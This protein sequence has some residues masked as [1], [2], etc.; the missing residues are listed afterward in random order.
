MRRLSSINDLRRYLAD[1]IRR[2]DPGTERLD[3]ATA[4]RLGNLLNLQK[5]FIT[6]GELEERIRRLEEEMGIKK[7]GQK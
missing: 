4:G 6:E 1:I 3:S 7:G 2:T 5:A